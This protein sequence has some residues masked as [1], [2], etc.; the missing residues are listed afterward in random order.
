MTRFSNDEQGRPML[1]FM[2]TADANGR[3]KSERFSRLIAT[4]AQGKVIKDYWDNKGKTH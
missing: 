3:I 4:D 1:L 2:G